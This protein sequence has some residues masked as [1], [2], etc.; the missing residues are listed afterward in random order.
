MRFVIAG[1]WC[2]VRVGGS[3]RLCCEC[4]HVYLASTLPYDRTLGS[5]SGD[6][7]SSKVMIGSFF[8]G[9]YVASSVLWNVSSIRVG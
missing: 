9:S 8:F 1:C 7:T 3:L 2:C 6:G 5:T 4:C